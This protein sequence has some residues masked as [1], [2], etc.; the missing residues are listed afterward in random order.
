MNFLN[1]LFKSVKLPEATV[2]VEIERKTITRVA[3]GIVVA[4]VVL[5]FLVFGIKKLLK[6]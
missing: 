3:I 2:N 5:T 1:N 6:A 4:G